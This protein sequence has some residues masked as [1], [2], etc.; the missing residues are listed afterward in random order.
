MQ[1]ILSKTELRQALHRDIQLMMPFYIGDKI[2][3]EIP[4][5]HIELWDEL[6]DLLDTVSDPSH[7]I[8]I[9]QKLLAI[10]REHAKTTLI[11]LAVLVFLRYSPLTFCAYVSNTSTVA[12]NAIADIVN[13]FTCENDA[14]LFGPSVI[15]RKSEKDQIYVL[16]IYRPDGTQKKIIMRAF[17]QQTQIRGSL[18][19]STRPDLLVFDDIESRETVD[20]ELQQK[21]LDAWAMGTAFKA[22]AKRGLCIFI[23]NMLG[24][25]SLL[26]RL[27]KMPSWNPTVLG[28]IVQLPDGTYAP[29]WPGRWTLEALIA[30]YHAFRSV[31][32]GHVWEAEM[33]NLTAQDIMGESLADVIKFELPNP[34]QIVGGFLTL[35]PGIKPTEKHDYSAIGVHVIPAPTATGMAH[36]IPMLVDIVKLRARHDEVFDEMLRLSQYWGITTWCI[37]SVAAQELLFP[38]Y[39][40]YMQQRGVQAHVLQLYPLSTGNK[41]KAARIVAFRRVLIAKS[42]SVAMHLGDFLARLENYTPLATGHD[43][44][45]DTAAYGPIA[46]ESYG[47]IVKTRGNKHGIFGRLLSGNTD[48]GRAI[49]IA[50]IP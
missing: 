25:T 17:G 45:Y 48:S 21:R 8:G 26:A 3:L 20:S 7:L 47:E 23:G 46:F 22:M 32:L 19:D 37:E 6:V 13:W 40:L 38:L 12:W 4:E 35:D 24:E 28:A 43:D 49:P 1:V 16:R 44:D 42:Y 30:D 18:V 5:M 14:E 41:A 10:P 9:L 2:D 50:G 31:G 29:L 34:E 36:P 11:K 33:M 39:K 15:E 27:S